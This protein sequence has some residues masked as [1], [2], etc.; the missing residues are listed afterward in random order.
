M[1]SQRLRRDLHFLQSMHGGSEMPRWGQGIEDFIAQM[2][3]TVKQKPHVLVAYAWVMYMAIF[4]GGRWIRAQLQSAGDQFWHCDKAS[5][6][7]GTPGMHLFCFDGERDGE[8]IK[9]DFKV[10]LEEAEGI[11]TPA[12]RQEV[13]Q[14][15]TNI[16]RFCITLVAD[17]DSRAE[18]WAQE[19]SQGIVS[20]QAPP[21]Y[22]ARFRFFRLSLAGWAVIVSFLS[23]YVYYKALF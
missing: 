9:A 23:W 4:S 3:E 8:D 1:R 11:F 18:M 10:R 2:R 14:E 21:S 6:L 13:V 12:Q 19:R 17:L 7:S 5:L 20:Q 22:F 15:A 16:F